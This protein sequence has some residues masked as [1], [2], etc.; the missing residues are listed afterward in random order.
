MHNVS[1][2]THVAFL[3]NIKTIKDESRDFHCD[4]MRST[5]SL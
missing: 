2:F 5:V 1:E 3:H 4:A